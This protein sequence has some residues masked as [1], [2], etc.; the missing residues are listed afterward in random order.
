W[1]AFEQSNSRGEMF[2]LEKGKCPRWDTW[3]SSYRL[4]S[5]PPI[6]MDSQEHKIYL[7]EEANFKGSTMEI[8][9]DDI[10]S[11]W[12]YGF[13]DRVGSVRVF[14][15]IWVGYQYPG[16]RGY[17]YLLEPGDLP[18]WTEWGAFQPQVQAV[19]RLRDRQWRREGCFPAPAPEP[20]K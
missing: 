1:A 6:R 13:C 3:P 10:P 8:Q 20:P 17:R 14:S 9:E 11:L 7:F 2:V 15:G 16:Y 18:H 5:F 12:A 4:M 19:C